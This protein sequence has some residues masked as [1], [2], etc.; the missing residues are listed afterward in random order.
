VFPVVEETGFVPVTADDVIT[1]GDT[2]NAKLDTLIDR[3]SVM[4]VELST[5]WTTAEYGM[6]IARMKGEEGQL[7]QRRLH[8]LLIVTKSEQVPPSAVDI[9]Y[10]IRPNVISGDPE[11]FIAE[12]R[13]RLQQIATETGVGRVAE[14]KRLLD[15]KEYRAAVISAMTLLEAA[16]RQQLDRQTSNNITRPVPIRSLIDIAVDRGLIPRDD[17][18]KID[19]WMR[20]RNEVVHNSATVTPSQAREIVDGVLQL[21]QGWS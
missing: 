16:L 20:V 10:V 19:S 7:S 5:A 12:L 3:S 1:P 13:R 6:A 21:V 18:K 11:P 17:K 15:A 14:P 8:L 2:V 4:L 9:P